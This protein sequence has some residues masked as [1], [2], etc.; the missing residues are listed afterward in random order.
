MIIASVFFYGSWNPIYIALILASVIANFLIGRKLAASDPTTQRLW[1]M[2]GLCFNLGLLAYFK[3]AGFFVDNLNTIGNWLIPMPNITLPLAISFFTFQQIAYL[4]DVA[5]GECEEYQFRHYSLF[6]LFFPQ[7]IAG[8]IVHHKEMMPQ[9]ERL[10]SR[11]ELLPD[12][13]VGLTI[14]A[15]GLFKKVVM[16]DSLAEFADP[17]FEAAGE[18][19]QVSFFDSWVATFAFSF[20]IYFDFSGYSDMAIGSARLFGIKLPE[21]FRSPYKSV[22]IIEFWRRWHITLSRFLRDYLY[23]TLGGNRDGR[24]KRYRN[25]FATMLLGG[26]WHGAAW[27]YVIWGGLHGMFLCV[28]H[29]WRALIQHSNPPKLF[30]QTWFRPLFILLTF[31]ASALAFTVFRAPD[32]NSAITIIA[33]GFV[34]GG[35]EVPLLLRGVIAESSLGQFL[36][37]GGLENGSY[38]AVYCLLFLAAGICW[39]LPNTQEFMRGFSP[40]IRSVFSTEVS[41]ALPAWRPGFVFAVTTA[42]LFSCSLLSLSSV[43]E[44]IYFQF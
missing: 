34:A 15:I 29:A 36:H 17:I 4:V 11:D 32:L 38:A 41:P 24:L 14:I 26:L 6:V 3:Y 9:F 37:A 28:N 27:T 13:A 35:A 40:V 20:Q 42:I 10:R 8:P 7:L 16:A 19:R 31:V 39:L 23:I 18:G 5:R 1:L 2:L 12:L 44:F 25:L 22:S 43:T 30:T 21:N 33:P